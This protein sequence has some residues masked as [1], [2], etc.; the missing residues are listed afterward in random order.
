M[1][2]VSKTIAKGSIQYAIGRYSTLFF[3]LLI[4]AVLARL[5]PPSD[6]AL[7]ALTTVVTSFFDLLANMGMAPAIIQ[8]KWFSKD[9][10]SDIFNFNIYIAVFLTAILILLSKPI[11]LFYNEPRL[12]SIL[13]LSSLQLIFTTLTVVPNALI[14]KEKKFKKISI[15]NVL[16]ALIAG[17][18]ALVCAFCGCGVYSL[19]V[20]SIGKSLLHFVFSYFYSP[21]RLSINLFFRYSSIKPLLSFSVYQ[22]SFNFINY[23]SRNLDKILIGR[24]LNLNDLGY[25]EKSYR[26]MILPISNIT[27]VVAPVIQPVL[28]GHS[29]DN[30]DLIKS[31]F[32]KL[33]KILTIFSCILSPICFFCAEEIILIVFGN[34]WYPSIPIFKILSLSIPFQ[35]IDSI[36]GAIL[37][38]ANKPKFLFISGLICAIVNIFSLV[39][40]LTLFHSIN[41]VAIFVSVSFALNLIIDIAFISRAIDY[42]FTDLISVF[43]KPFIFLVAVSFILYCLSYITTS[44]LISFTLKLSVVLIL[45]FCFIKWTKYIDLSKL[46]RKE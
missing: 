15:I 29:D 41:V 35:L 39:I 2:S 13:C 43:I 25:Y 16:S 27:G 5:L 7:I 46:L 14:L 31:T 44:L 30:N 19:L 26:L 32:T 1:S 11:S 40:S 9:E 18:A 33:V 23:F 34:Q 20:L 45:C 12:F 22:F 21:I 36:T 42:R 37:Q 28:A 10:Y 4:S 8:N 3:N 24:Y 38:S 17:I 6:F